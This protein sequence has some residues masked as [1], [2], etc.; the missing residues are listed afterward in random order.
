M[1]ILIYT[2]LGLV[3]LVLWFAIITAVVWAWEVLV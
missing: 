2:F 3:S 1:N